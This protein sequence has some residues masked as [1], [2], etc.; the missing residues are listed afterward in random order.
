MN[1]KATKMGAVF[2]IMGEYPTSAN[3]N[4]LHKGYMQSNVY[5][6]CMILYHLS[7]ALKQ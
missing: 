5:K 1:C 6:I 4:K 2:I 7:K 3:K